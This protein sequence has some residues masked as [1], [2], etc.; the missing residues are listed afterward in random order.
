MRSRS[1]RVIRSCRVEDSAGTVLAS[2]ACRTIT[3]VTDL[4]TPQ[5]FKDLMARFAATVTV[6]TADTDEGP[7]GMTVTAFTSVSADP[8]IVLVCVDRRQGSADLYRDAKG[9]TVNFMPRGEGDLAMVYATHGADKF[10]ATG[11]TPTDGP[12][13]PVL[14]VAYGYLEC[15][16]ID[17]A[18]VGDHW[19]V[20]AEVV[21][22]AL[23]SD[24]SPLLWHDR[25]FADL[26]PGD[27]PS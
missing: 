11:T 26:V 12:G 16:T 23:T 18:E 14:D 25:G 5:Q 1:C 7:I 24:A 8:P 22:A 17:V 21:D 3:A 4:V 13:G 20:Y 10:G 27:D 15:R 9:Y 6:V 2:R 19:V